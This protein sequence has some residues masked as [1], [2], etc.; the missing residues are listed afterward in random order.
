MLP[1]NTAP[2]F[3][4]L[5]TQESFLTVLSKK[6]LHGLRMAELFSCAPSRS[7]VIKAGLLGCTA[8]K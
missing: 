8:G 2:G 1:G 6:Q 4:E 3:E 5:V 7:M